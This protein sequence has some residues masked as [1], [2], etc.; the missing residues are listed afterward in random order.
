MIC[1]VFLTVLKKLCFLLRILSSYPVS[2]HSMSR[3]KD[4]YIVYKKITRENSR[5]EKKKWK[6]KPNLEY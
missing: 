6:K 4:L 5:N 3:V 2:L 1:T